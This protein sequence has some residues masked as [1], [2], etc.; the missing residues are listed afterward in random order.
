[1]RNIVLLDGTDSTAGAKTEKTFSSP[2]AR[3]AIY[4]SG[5]SSDSVDVEYRPDSGESWVSIL[6][7]AYTDDIVES[8]HPCPAGEYR[9]NKIGSSD[10]PTVILLGDFY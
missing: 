2:K 3:A 7:A 5:L 4:V 10:S 8:F 9:V 1:M 6:D